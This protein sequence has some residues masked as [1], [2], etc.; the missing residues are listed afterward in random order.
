METTGRLK[1]ISELLNGRFLITF[2]VNAIYDPE[3]LRGCDVDIKATKHRDK[4]SLTA[5]AYFHV[6]VDKISK[7]IGISATEAKNSLI[8]DYGQLQYQESGA[9]D[10]AAKP[11]GFNYLKCTETHYRPSGE[12]VCSLDGSRQFEIYW[13]MRGSHTYNTE[14]MSK[15]IDGTVSEA[16][17]LGI[18]TLTPAEQERMLNAWSIS[19]R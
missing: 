19:Q 14:E 16:K 7:K 2:E 6:L 12:H 13:V 1:D 11:E 9:I 18:E 10:W 3:E 17:E 8:S 4:R 5:N 15:L